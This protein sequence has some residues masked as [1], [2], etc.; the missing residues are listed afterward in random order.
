LKKEKENKWG[1][2][3]KK[4]KKTQKCHKQLHIDLASKGFLPVDQYMSLK[5]LSVKCD[6][7]T[8]ELNEIAAREESEEGSDEANALDISVSNA[9]ASEAEFVRGLSERLH[10]V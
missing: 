10:N 7:L 8:P 1:V 5:G 4:S 6:K 2:Y 3:S 9:S